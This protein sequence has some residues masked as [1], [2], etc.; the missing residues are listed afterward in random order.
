MNKRNIPF[1]SIL[2]LILSVCLFL[3]ACGSNATPTT[4]SSSG[5]TSAGQTLMEQRCTVCHSVSR[6]TSAHHTA[7]EWKTTVDRMINKGA[8]LSSSEEQTLLDY[9]AKNYK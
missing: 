4:A 7:A 2:F 1:I 8:Q 6:I 5:A 9:L 3:A